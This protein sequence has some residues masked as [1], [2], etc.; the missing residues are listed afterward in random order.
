MSLSPTIGPSLG[1]FDCGWVCGFTRCW[2]L[3]LVFSSNLGLKGVGLGS[4]V[5]VGGR[6]GGGYTTV[7]S[8]LVELDRYVGRGVVGLVPNIRLNFSSAELDILVIF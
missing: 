6:V 8:F 1:W 7:T 2:V 5:L 3:G 4:G